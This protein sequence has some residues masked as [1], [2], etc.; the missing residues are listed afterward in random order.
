MNDSGSIT[1]ARTDTDLAATWSATIAVLVRALPVV[2][3]E[4]ARLDPLVAR[5]AATLV[6]LTRSPRLRAAVPDSGGIADTLSQ[7]LASAPAAAPAAE[8]PL[9]ADALHA[10]RDAI[11]ASVRRLTTLTRIGHALPRLPRPVPQLLADAEAMLGDAVARRDHELTATLLTVWPLLGGV[12]TATA[13]CAL[14]DLLATHAAYGFLP[15]LD[16]PVAPV[17]ED[18][19][20]AGA[21]P[22]GAL[23]LLLTLLLEHAAVPQPWAATDTDAAVCRAL[24]P[25]AGVVDATLAVS[26]ALRQAM[27]T[28]DRRAVLAI[29]EIAL[30]AGVEA[31]SA[32]AAAVEDLAGHGPFAAARVA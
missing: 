18:L 27:R 32:I 14:D 31:E 21:G 13:R 26:G 24:I 8:A 7:V 16:G 22:T 28:A 4:P 19:L 3:D 30:G 9:V 25:D 17:G 10:D 15:P 20:R 6:V 29:L 23:A 1:N 11:L 5:S 12:W 2:A